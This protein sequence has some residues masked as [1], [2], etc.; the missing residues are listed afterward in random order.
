MM[1]NV[2]YL[3]LAVLIGIF[4]IQQQTIAQYEGANAR[5][6]LLF[7]TYDLMGCSVI[8]VCDHGIVFEYYNGYS[9]K[10]RALPIDEKTA[11]RIASISKNISTILLLKLAQEGKIDLDEDVNKYLPFEIR[12]PN[13][14]NQ[15]LTSRMFLSH[16]SSIIDGSGYSGF[17]S[18]TYASDVPPSL[19]ELLDPTGSFYTPDL[20]LGVPPGTYFNYSNLNYGVVA[21]LVEA[22]SGQRFDR[23]ADEILF[24]PLGLDAGYHPSYLSEINHLAVLYRKQGSQWVSQWDEYG[25]ESPELPALEGYMPGM[26]GLFFSPQGGVRMN[27]KDLALILALHLNDG[28]LNG[29]EILNNTY[30]NLMEQPVWNFDGNNGNNYFGLFR[31]WGM[32]THISTNAPNADVIFPGRE[33]RGH[34]GEAY[35]LIS[36]MYYDKE[37]GSGV[38]F[39]TN[40]SGK[41]YNTGNSAFYTLEDSIFRIIYEEVILPC[42]LSLSAE[43]DVPAELDIFPNPVSATLYLKGAYSFPEALIQITDLHGKVI[44]EY[45]VSI[46]ELDVSKLSAGSYLINITDKFGSVTVQRKFIKQ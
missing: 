24:K 43:M 29:I 26:N 45:P 3:K 14:P 27:A 46:N 8:G 25:G 11:Y 16:Q 30:Q 9:D 2:R 12:N 34:P 13:F 21:S 28:T 35:G 39:M 22:A 6:D 41:G 23:Y 7:D 37:S 20:Y 31:S 1:L 33:M 44:A 4:G 36:D 38:I 18:A 15:P 10:E 19:E 5:L 32:G 17:L 42:Q 40:G